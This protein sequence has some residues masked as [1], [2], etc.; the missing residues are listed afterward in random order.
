MSKPILSFCEKT[1]THLKNV[2]KQMVCRIKR[3]LK[4]ELVRTRVCRAFVCKNNSNNKV[5][6]ISRICIKR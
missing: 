4:I 1:V 3:N 2:V 6:G 5:N